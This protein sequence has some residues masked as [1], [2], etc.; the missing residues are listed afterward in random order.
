MNCKL[1]EHSSENVSNLPSCAFRLIRSPNFLHYSPSFGRSVP[2]FS[3][4]VVILSTNLTD[5]LPVLIS[6]IL[7]P[8]GTQVIVSRHFVHRQRP[9]F[10]FLIG[11]ASLGKHTRSVSTTSVSQLEFRL[12]LNVYLQVHIPLL[13]LNAF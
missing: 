5:S 12:R 1:F 9:K 11:Y 4:W 10:K 13:L 7:V 8:T 6:L 3:M 2:L